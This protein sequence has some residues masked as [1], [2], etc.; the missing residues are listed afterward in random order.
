[1]RTNRFVIY[2]RASVFIF[3]IYLPISWVFNSILNANYWKWWEMALSALLSV[4]VFG[5]FAWIV[6]NI[7][8]FLIYGRTS[9]YKAYR[10]GGGDPFFDILPWF[11]NP[12]SKIVRETGMEEPNTNFVP[13]SDWEFQCPKCGARQPTRVCVCWNCHYGADSDSTAYFQ[14]H[15][16]VKP[17]EI[18]E[19]EWAEIR[20]RHNV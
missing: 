12:D 7:G 2:I 13:P 11:I 8:V 3:L 14:Q 18:S 1:M 10:N 4:A 20:S 19:D 16:D 9:Y 6:T 5:G 15:G 17:L